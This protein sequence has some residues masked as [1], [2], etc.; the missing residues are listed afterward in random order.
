MAIYTLKTEDSQKKLYLSERNIYGSS[1][2]GMENVNYLIAST[3]TTNIE[4]YAHEKVVVGDKAFEL[5]N[6][7]G[8]FNDTWVLSNKTLSGINPVRN[9]SE[10]TGVLN[11]IT[12]KKLPEF[13]AT[14][15]DL[16]FFNAV[17]VGYSDY[18]PFGMQMPGRHGSDNA[19][20]YR[21]GFNGMESIDEVSGAKNSYDFG[22]RLYNPRIARWMSTDAYES[23]YP[24]STP[25]NFAVN[26]P[27][28]FID[29]DGND[30][31]I[32]L[33]Y[34]HDEKNPQLKGVS[35]QSIANEAN[36]MYEKLGLETRVVVFDENKRGAFN[37]NYMDKTDV[38]AIVADNK[39]IYADIKMSPGKT[40]LGI[41]TNGGQYAGV[42]TENANQYADLPAES[43]SQLLAFGLLHE[44]G[45]LASQDKENNDHTQFFDRTDGTRKGPVPSNDYLNFMAAGSLLQVFFSNDNNSG[46]TFG[47]GVLFKAEYI[48]EIKE[49]NQWITDFMDLFEKCNNQINIDNFEKKFGTKE[50]SAN[51]DN[52]KKKAES[53]SK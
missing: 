38:Y 34:H 6:H 1:R 15:G 20:S 51:Y 3:N 5:S 4:A 9:L 25:Y 35:A 40:S 39:T 45:H 21:Y 2:L 33:V 28:L 18:Y 8:N 13:D 22:A 26:N 27:L 10:A 41:S 23:K 12:D 29:P 48:K 31:V 52:K 19:D 53:T 47:E 44:T 42:S 50:A 14:T 24:S 49:S 16:A 46:F 37:A 36:K 43:M 11:T 32:Y 17:V 7:L 30:N